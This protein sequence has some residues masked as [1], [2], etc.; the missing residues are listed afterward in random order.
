MAYNPSIVLSWF[1]LKY[2]FKKDDSFTVE[3]KG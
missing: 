2:S 1:K 3:D